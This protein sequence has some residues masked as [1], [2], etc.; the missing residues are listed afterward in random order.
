M[1]TSAQIKSLLKSHYDKNDDRFTTLALQ[2]AAA[3][4]QKG[5]DAIAREIRELVDK[6]KSSPIKV[7]SFN[8]DL[9]DLILSTQPHNRLAN[10][11]VSSDL[12]KKIERVLR[13]YHQ[14]DKLRRHGLSNRRK[15]LLAGSPGTGK[16]MTASV[17]AGELKLPFFT[18]QMDKLVTKFM[19]ETSAKMRQIFDVIAKRRGVFL[20]DEFD[21]IGAERGLNNDVGEMRRVL[22][23]F[24]QFI[25]QDT[26]ES[27][28]ITAT[29]NINLL[30]QALFR[31]F[32]D[33]LRYNLPK[34]D[35]I[36]QLIMNH[37][38]T[39]RGKFEVKDLIAESK[40]LSHAEITQ[41]C[42]DAIKEAILTDK[43]KVTKKSLVSMLHDRRI[44]YK[45][46]TIK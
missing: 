1:V 23:S 28:I 27:I 16:T 37:L 18:I 38:G 7:I 41:A 33:I 2:V 17:I 6:G 21:A 3:E 20:F 26:S 22:N 12:K 14:Q 24:L 8:G 40:N 15:L 35:E 44:A 31:R 46:N 11:I 29:N 39:F 43:T 25:E 13:E 36:I 30:D 45:N 19:G 5:R 42:D 32:D 9:D 34:D 4:A 10:L